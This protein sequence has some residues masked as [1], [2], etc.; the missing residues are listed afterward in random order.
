MTAASASR[1]RA[2]QRGARSEILAAWYLRLK[3]YR[4]LTRRYKAT[5][6]EIDLIAAR[7]SVVAFVE[8]KARDD[9]AQALAAVTPRQR[10]RIESAAGTFISHNRRYHRHRLR[11]DIIVVGR[12]NWPEHLI[13]AWRPGWG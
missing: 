6:G 1:R 11:F 13:Q 9:R 2:Y 5:G 12:R 8:V 4:I 7:G 3:G 10:R